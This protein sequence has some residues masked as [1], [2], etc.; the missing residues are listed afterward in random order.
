M[1]LLTDAGITISRL[2]EYAVAIEVIQGGHRPS[3]R[4]VRS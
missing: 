3:A 4:K 2:P 1:I